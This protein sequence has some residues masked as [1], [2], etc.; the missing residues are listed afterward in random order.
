M[1][2]SLLPLVLI[3]VA[4]VGGIII[5]ILAVLQPKALEASAG[6][7]AQSESTPLGR[8]R[9]EKSKDQLRDRLVY[10]GLYRRNSPSFFYAMQLCFVVLPIVT[11]LVAYNLGLLRL[12]PAILLGTIFG[13]AGVVLPGLWLDYRKAKRQTNI[14]RAIPDALDVIT[15]CVEAGLS[16][17]SA[18]VRVSKDLANTHPL[19]ATELTIVHRHM[20]MGKTAGEALRSFAERFDLGE[21]RSLSSVVTQSEKFGASISSA[22]RVHAETLRT[23]RMQKAHEKAQKAAIWI[24]LPTVFCIFPALFVV[25]LGPAAFDIAELIRT[26]GK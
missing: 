15:I 12:Y 16:L 13:L 14:R 4:I 23:K 8:T 7:T 3:A 18:I 2:T 1:D 26:M 5:V 6:G 24:L 17:S 20:Q 9:E 19:L 25:I 11:G 22:L 10:A 21:L